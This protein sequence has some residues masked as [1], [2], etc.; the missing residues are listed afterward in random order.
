MA[1]GRLI[2]ILASIAAV[3]GALLGALTAF[4]A[5]KFRGDIR[6]GEKRRAVQK[7]RPRRYPSAESCDSE[8]KPELAAAGHH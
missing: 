5:I 1:T 3:S 6:K 8:R 2:I 4:I 7:L